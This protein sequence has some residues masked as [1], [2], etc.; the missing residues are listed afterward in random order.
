MTNS[1]NIQDN[2]KVPITLSWL[3]REGLQFMKTLSEEKEKCETSMGLFSV[4]GEK[5][6]PQ[7][8]TII[9]LQYFKLTRQTQ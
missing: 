1:Y 2:E 4:L 8:K 9:S 7:Q 5:V 3:G 6:E